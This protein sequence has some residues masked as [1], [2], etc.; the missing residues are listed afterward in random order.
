MPVLRGLTENAFGALLDRLD[1][2]RGRAAERYEELRRMLLR[3]FEWR[4]AP[5]PDE[6]TDETFNRVA[7]KL[8]EGVAIENIGGYI[9]KVA[10]LV[11]LE[12]RK[13]P[14][15]KRV[16]LDTS[17][18]MAA[19]DLASEA[20]EK[21]RR[22]ACLDDCLRE[23]PAESRELI[24]AYYRDD[25]Q[26]RIE[27]RRRLAE[28]LGLRAEALANRAQRLRDKLERCVRACVTRNSST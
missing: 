16:P 18:P 14:D 11:Y 7:R 23:L 10:R 12:T 26:G 4:G 20:A 5:F 25:T 24:V 9:Y 19:A 6:H 13:G 28:R 3:F 2:D 22:L 15:A 8:A 27:G 21:E 1:R 17:R